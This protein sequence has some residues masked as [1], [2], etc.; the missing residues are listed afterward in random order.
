MQVSFPRNGCVLGDVLEKELAETHV[1]PK[2]FVIPTLGKRDVEIYVKDM[3]GRD[4]CLQGRATIS[5]MVNQPILCYGK[6]M[7][8]GWSLNAMEQTAERPPTPARIPVDVQNRSLVILGHIRIMKEKPHYV[9]ALRAVLR[10]A[11]QG[12]RH[13][14]L[15]RTALIQ[16][17]DG[18]WEMVE[19]CEQLSEM[20][21]NDVKFEEPGMRGVIAVLA[22][23]NV[24]PEAMGFDLEDE[25]VM[26]EPA[27]ENFA[28]EVRMAPEDERVVDEVEPNQDGL[29]AEQVERQMEEAPGVLKVNER[30]LMR[31]SWSL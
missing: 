6:L 22:D 28:W 17:Q 25:F 21:F 13:E 1:M 5:D 12:L 20:V 18:H 16:G 30:N 31:S 4:V 3:T 8:Q 15:H 19:F 27:G 2:K 9:R 29:Q 23:T 24:L 26:P 11:F 7:E 14:D 10:E